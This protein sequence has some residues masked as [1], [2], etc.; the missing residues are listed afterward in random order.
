MLNP[1]QSGEVKPNIMSWRSLF[2]ATVLMCAASYG[3]AGCVE[4]L[5]PKSDPLAK[6]NRDRTALMF[7][8]EGGHAA[9]VELLLPVSDPLARDC[10]GNTA[11]MLAGANGHAKCLEFLL[12]VS[13][14]DTANQYGET[15]VNLTTDL[16][17]LGELA[18]HRY[19]RNQSLLESMIERSP[20]RPRDEE[21]SKGNGIS[22]GAA[23]APPPALMAGE[24][25]RNVKRRKAAP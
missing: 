14:L 1:S 4:M 2:G 19:A 8:A 9:C 20:P 22:V 15:V 16:L 3:N 24:W 23:L 13:D 6:D 12:P 5:L 10:E 7:A 11:L 25:A 18:R 17:C 21:P